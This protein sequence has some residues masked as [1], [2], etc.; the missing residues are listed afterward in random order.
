LYLEY[1][2]APSTV[3]TI[4][5]GILKAQ[6]HYPVRQL[7]ESVC[8]GL[9]SKDYLSEIICWDTF[10]ASR[11]RYMRDPRTVELVRA[12]HVTIQEILTNGIA[13]LDCD[14]EA[15]LEGA[16]HLLM[17]CEVRL[18]TV[19][20]KHMFYK[21]QRQYSHVFEQAREPK[22]G[23]WITCDPVAGSETENMLRRVVAAKVWPVA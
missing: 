20:F 14:D 4:I 19:A 9:R 3:T 2:G 1:R 12:P 18:V 8:G 22:S 23:V 21:G 10:C 15:A 17:G 11:T 16:G 13:N 6:N 7:V 5:D